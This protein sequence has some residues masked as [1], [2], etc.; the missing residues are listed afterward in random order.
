MMDYWRQLGIFNPKSHRGQSIA[1]IGAGAIGSMTALTLAKMGLDNIK[2]WDEDRIEEHNFPNQMYPISAK[3]ELKVIALKDNI[4]NMTG[5]EI[6]PVERMWNNDEFDG[7]SIV[8][9]ATDNMK[10]RK[11]IWKRVKL[12][13]SIK[14]FIDGRMGGELMR[15]YTVNPMSIKE[16]EQYEKTLYTDKKAE[17][18]PCTEQSIIYN[19]SGIGGFI[20][21][22]VKKVLKGEDYPNEIIFDY[23]CMVMETKRWS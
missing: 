18:R 21:N 11:D 13:P 4:L 17:T 12:R 6:T 14:L 7:D 19:L 1:L 2:V 23:K 8:I 9:V 22:Q 15:I 5:S 3:G 10:S 16:A 20:A